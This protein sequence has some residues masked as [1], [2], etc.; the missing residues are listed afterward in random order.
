MDELNNIDEIEVIDPPSGIER[1]HKKAQNIAEG[2]GTRKAS[3]QDYQQLTREL[4]PAIDRFLRRTFNS[5][6][7][8]IAI[9]K[10]DSH[11]ERIVS[12]KNQI[13]TEHLSQDSIPDDLDT[14]SELSKALRSGEVDL[15][16][17]EKII[18]V[19]PDLQGFT[20]DDAVSLIQGGE[21]AQSIH[22]KFPDANT[23][24]MMAV[25][26]TL[27]DN[28]KDVLKQSHPRFYLDNR[29]ENFAEMAAV[30]IFYGKVD[31]QLYTAWEANKRTEVVERISNS[32]EI[33]SALNTIRSGNNVN[34][35]E[36]VQEQYE[37]R[38]VV[39]KGVA[40]IY[41]EV[42]GLDTFNCDDVSVAHKS[43]KNFRAENVNGVAWSTEV[44]I[45]GDEAV[46]L[47]HNPYQRLM[48]GSNPE[49]TNEEARENFLYTTIE[50]MQHTA[51]KIYGDKLVNGDIS[52]DHPAYDHST[53]ITLNSLNFMSPG[54]DRKG[55]E[56]Q[57]IERTAKDIAESVT[58]QVLH[59]LET[60]GIPEAQDQI[61]HTQTMITSEPVMQVT[62]PK[63]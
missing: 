6:H 1:A 51:D 63:I 34:S 44:G 59:S 13:I 4:D 16:S 54:R 49:D 43:L 9:N 14:I 5:A 39:A 56:T 40:D 17:V 41:S 38:S 53:L 2:V 46:I 11:T 22:Q 3:Q 31:N 48:V 47:F 23:D 15:R 18:D 45:K 28:N 42:Y 60:S 32:H 33:M 12:A 21:Q 58:D 50:E 25:A 29:G 36:E 26:Y 55:Y 37:A 61:E 52:A 10:R 19:R 7:D 57:F 8:D 27:L 24:I 30:N 20:L 62:N 35:L